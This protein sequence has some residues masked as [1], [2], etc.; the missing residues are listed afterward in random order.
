MQRAAQA[1]AVMAQQQ[2]MLSTS[3]PLKY[4]EGAGQ[5]LEGLAVQ[6]S[7]DTFFLD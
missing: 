2:L 1:V 7:L 4:E 6:A 3:F 5:S